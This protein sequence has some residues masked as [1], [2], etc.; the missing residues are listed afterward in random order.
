MD[1]V[2]RNKLKTDKFAVEVEHTVEYVAEHRKQVTIYGAI[3]VAVAIVA[4]GIW[5]YRGE[6][7]STR[8]KDLA[9]AME[10]QNAPV[11]PAPPAGTV[12]PPRYFTTQALKNT[13]VSKAFSAVR[14]KHAGST[15]A[16]IA[17][18]YLGA[19]AADEGKLPEAEKYFQAAIADG[20]ANY[21]SIAKLS[22][23]QILV[24]TGRVPE[25][26][27]LLRSLADNPT[28]FV[29]KEQ[30]TI[31]LARAIGTTKPAEARKLLEP[32][33]ATPGAVSQ[34]AITALNQL[35]GQ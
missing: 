12:A 20:D 2:T 23:S 24:A 34:A 30:A 32:L 17:A 14:A 5:Y 8:Q 31:A 19:I 16:V 1:R 29:S 27:K 21:G 22:L 28:L 10:K 26:E 11:M 33:R 15:E 9:E 4:A 6:Q 18:S 3:A 13:E 25:A 7:H 35:P